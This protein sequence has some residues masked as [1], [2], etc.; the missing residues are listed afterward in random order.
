M[1][2]WLRET[3]DKIM[4]WGLLIGN[5]IDLDHIY[6]RIIGKVGWFESACENGIGTQCSFIV[7]HL[8]SY[9][10]IGFLATI[11]ILSV[12]HLNKLQKN[13]MNTENTK[14]ILW[15]S[16]GGLVHLMLDYIHLIINWAI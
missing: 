4:L 2:Y 9:F 8:H 14:I 16:V 13:N 7:Y 5:I 15:I 10:M 12:K 11:V 1:I 3:E 6:M